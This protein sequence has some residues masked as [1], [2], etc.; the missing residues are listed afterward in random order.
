MKKL[1]QEMKDSLARSREWLRKFAIEKDDDLKRI[2][3]ASSD[4][5]LRG[6]L[7]EI[8]PQG[9]EYA[10]LNYH[11]LI[12]GKLDGEDIDTP[13]NWIL[14][15]SDQEFSYDDAKDVALN[16]GELALLHRLFKVADMAEEAQEAQSLIYSDTVYG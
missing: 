16:D 1:I 9:D 2:L 4:D 15:L 10:N 7:S 3:E 8:E 6:L 11:D 14:S 12:Q 13:E 5:Q